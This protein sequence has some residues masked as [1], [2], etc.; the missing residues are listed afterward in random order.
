MFTVSKRDNKILAF[1]R[2][3]RRHH[4]LPTCFKENPNNLP[5]NGR[6]KD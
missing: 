1:M 3:D 2:L 4:I 6:G 5:V